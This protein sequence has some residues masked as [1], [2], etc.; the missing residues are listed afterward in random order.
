[1]TDPAFDSATDALARAVAELSA[2]ASDP[3][4]RITGALEVRRAAESLL[5]A[6]VDAARA[7]GVTWQAIGDV[8]GT[9]RQ[10]AFQRFGHPIDPR[11]GAPMTKTV[12]P[13]AAGRA[14]AVFALISTLQWDEVYSQFDETMTSQIT[15]DKLAEGWAMAAAT[16]GAFESQGEPFVRAAEPYTLVDV[17]LAFEAGDMVGRVAYNDA[18]QISGLFI[19]TPSAAAGL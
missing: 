14:S 4:G 6:S 17:P 1:M 13:D 11:T 18:G 3:V 2:P 5:G 8:L 16:A 12:L 10:A 9:S 7:A 19:L 15:V